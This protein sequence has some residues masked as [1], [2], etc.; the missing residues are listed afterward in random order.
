MSPRHPGVSAAPN[1][2]EIKL[3]VV[4]VTCSERFPDKQELVF[5][6]LAARPI[7][8]P[9]F[10]TQRI[11]QSVNGFTFD[12]SVT[13]TA[14]VLANAEAEYLGGARQGSF[15]LSNLKASTP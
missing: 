14:G 3:R 4:S 1:R 5:E 13:L 15:Q 2:C 11:G 6:L 8:G 12:T 9:D 7:E 10:A